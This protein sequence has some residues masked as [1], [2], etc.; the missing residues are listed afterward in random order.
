MLK[1]MTIGKKINIGVASVSLVALLASFLILSWYAVQIENDVDKKF[2]KNLQKETNYK[3]N[4]KKNIGI[5]NA[6]SIANDG[7]IKKALRTNDRKWAI[8]TLNFISEKFKKSTKFKNI[9]IHVHTK[10][11]K[12]F[13]RIW[14][15]K[16]FGDDLSG[17]RH[18]IVKVNQTQNAVNTFEL[19]KAGLS[20]RS[21]VPITDDDGTHLGS[22]EFMQGLN[23]VAKA[24][25][26]NK[27]GF[28]LLMDKRVS[29][30]KQFKEEK[31]YKTNYIISQKFINNS[32][33][34]DAKK[35]DI[36]KLLK[37]KKYE[38]DKFLYTYVNVK[39]FRDKKLGIAIVGS[40]LEKV[41]SAVN[42]AKEII[43]IA[44]FIVVGLVIFIII[45][46]VYA[47][48]KLVVVPLEDLTFGI[49]EFFRY[50]NKQSSSATLLVSKS[51]DEFG[52][53]TNII[54]DNITKT[55]ELIK[56]DEELLKDVKGV[57]DLV[58]DGY[59]KQEVKATTQN[60]E[61]EKL[62]ITIN[63]M[64]RAISSNVSTDIN[65][66][67]IILNEFH[68]L[69]FSH[70]VPNATGKTALALNSLADIINKML[71]DNKSNGLTL[72]DSS[73][74]LLS[75]VD[76]LNKSSNEAAASLEETAAS[77]EE[78]TAN[79]AVNTQN[80]IQM[81]NHGN[82]LKNSVSD[83]QKLANQTTTAMDEI[84]SEVT[85]ISE[86]IGVIDQISFQTNILSLNAA[87]EAATA[88]EAGKGFAVV[89]QE[90][91]NLASRSAEAANEI[92]SLVYNATSKANNGKLIADE[93]IDG[94]SELHASIAKTLNLLTDI[95][96]ASKEQKNG[97]EQINDAITMLDQQTQ[98]NASV[99][100][101]AK[102]IAVQTQQIAYDIVKDAD[103]KE[104]VG[105]DSVKARKI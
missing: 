96:N 65:K 8:K 101:Y 28:M 5:T 98:Q 90:V 74:I 92:K 59:I 14:K 17:F 80:V 76:K 94:Y 31:I 69:N 95:E 40:P 52:I 78:M 26:K 66:V 10:D 68:D 77:L 32:F 37:D 23:S 97:I 2:I 53:I 36:E 54:N 60:K 6:I 99:A 75:N 18:S 62:K 38:T 67:Q 39:D 73:D 21:V 20:L 70:R 85:A 45:A 91:R 19:G 61:L 24:F 51:N 1:N 84:N 22:L 100:G 13:V 88:G 7:R 29:S 12:S 55:Q 30:M 42:S 16:K 46:I 93:M 58:K 43:N 102:N 81:A 25:D 104:F 48:R 4:I 105:K 9:K 82:E 11:N 57:V 89:A 33:L 87:V 3:F 15:L 64:L 86:A 83:G 41:N 63:E 50:L 71:V 103:E 44:L 47:V 49:V 72:K 35:I 34:N 27:E 79:M 56:Q